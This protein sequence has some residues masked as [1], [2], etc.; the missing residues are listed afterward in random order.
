[1]RLIDAAS[2]KLVSKRDDELPPYAILS[3][4]WGSDEDE[5]SFEEM[6]SFSTSFRK[7]TLFTHPVARKAGFAKIQ[8]SARLALSQGLQYI[9]IDTCCINKNSSA[10][11]SEA[12]NSMFRW[13]QSSAVCY[14]FLSDVSVTAEEAGEILANYLY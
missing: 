14:A 5:V 4:T 9:W 6:Q 12:I 10:E 11:L 13:Y 3:H 8:Q 7:S 1:M 2:L